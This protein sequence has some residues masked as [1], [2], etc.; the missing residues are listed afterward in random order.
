MTAPQS[1]DD[2]KGWFKPLDQALFGWFLERQRDEPP[3]D[4]VELGAYLGKSA[5]LIGRHLRAGERFTVCDLFETPAEDFRNQQEYNNSYSNLARA[6]F[7][8]NYLAFHAELPVIVQGP[9]SAILDHVA[10]GSCRFVHV[11]AS[12]LYEHVAH[13]VDAAHAMLRP[14]GVAVFDDFRAEHT[15]GTAAAVWEGVFT[16]G[17]HPICLT[18]NKLYGTWGDPAPLQESLID[19]LAGEPDFLHHPQQIA[20]RPV[21]RVWAR[22]KPKPKPKPPAPRKPPPQRSLA[23]RVAVDLL[24]PVVTRSVRRILH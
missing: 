9:T 7:E 12:H 4:L 13:D 21:L 1:L 16:K 19:W 15:P 22:P 3:G 5:I 17:L 24:P 8:T 10:A 14:D 20:D 6:A 2:V 11:D 23:K 18:A